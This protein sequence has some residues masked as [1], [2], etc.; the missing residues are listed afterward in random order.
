[1][2]PAL[3]HWESFYVIVGSSAAAL[4]GLQFVVL[5][6]VAEST[7][8][9]SGRQIAAFGT[10]VV[11]HFGSTLLIS[12][13]LSA[14][15]TSMAPVGL[16]MSV[17]GV[18]GILYGVAVIRRARTQQEYSPVASDWI[19]HTVLPNFAYAAV[20]LAAMAMHKSE[21]LALFI[22]G[23]S[24]LLLLFIGIHNSW[25]TVTYIVITNREKQRRHHERDSAPTDK[26]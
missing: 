19:W 8:S 3:T 26:A 5:T 15:W 25:D 16:C 1:M 14:P 24:A 13:I 9:T 12:A 10:P 20:L 18:A 6:L 2:I 11:V 21:E 17:L 22:I 7:L 23:G 4:T